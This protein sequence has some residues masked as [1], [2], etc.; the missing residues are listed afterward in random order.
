MLITNLENICQRSNSDHTSEGLWSLKAGPLRRQKKKAS[1]FPAI[2][3]I[4]LL[5]KVACFLLVYPFFFVGGVIDTNIR[6]SIETLGFLRH[7]KPD[8]VEKGNFFVFLWLK[9][10]ID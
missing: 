9:T 4:P 6:Y 1:I 5:M 2:S 8:I 7:Y 3:T 10:K